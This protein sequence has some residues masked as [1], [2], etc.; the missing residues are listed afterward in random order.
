[1]RSVSTATSRNTSITWQ[2]HSRNPTTPFLIGEK[3][4]SLNYV[5]HLAVASQRMKSIEIVQLFP[6][7]N[8]V[9]QRRFDHRRRDAINA[10][11]IWRKLNGQ[12]SCQSMNAAFGGGGTT[13]R[14]RCDCMV[15]PHGANIDNRSTSLIHHGL[16]SELRSYKVT[17]QKT[18]ITVQIVSSMFKKRL[19]CE[20]AGIIYENIH[21]AKS[22]DCQCNEF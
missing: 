1:M 22:A 16:D 21:T 20:N 19:W 12:I 15:R 8:R 10:Y 13:A 3:Q 11:F 2:N 4:K 7:K 17:S 9:K 5:I 14:G 18:K 6:S